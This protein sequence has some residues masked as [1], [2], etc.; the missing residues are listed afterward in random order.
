ML[1]RRYHLIH[2]LFPTPPHRAEAKRSKE[3]V[4]DRESSEENMAMCIDLKLKLYLLRKKAERKRS[5]SPTTVLVS[6][7][8]TWTFFK[9]EGSPPPFFRKCN[10]PQ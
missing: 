10:S 6:T 7:L 4:D 9:G 8:Q 3:R 2:L 5:G 1:R